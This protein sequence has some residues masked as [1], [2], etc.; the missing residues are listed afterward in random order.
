MNDQSRIDFE[1]WAATK[2]MAMHLARADSGLYVSRVTQNYMDCWMAS[3]TWQPA[4]IE[5]LRKYGEEFA[6]LAERR[7]EQVEAL[8]SQVKALQSDA[9]SYQSGYDAGRAVAKAHADSWRAEAEA[10]RK[11]AKPLDPVT[12]NQLPAIGS[13][14]LIHLGRSDAWVEHT[15]VGYYA[16]GDLGGNQSLH[17]VFVRVRDADGYL[18]ARLL[19]DVRTQVAMGKES[20]HD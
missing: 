19:K 18:N 7:R 12:G 6:S 4:E 20:S 11:D 2:G 9:N 15:V 16:W 14:V 8:A 10:L 3:R 13:E 5:A 1:A 17:R